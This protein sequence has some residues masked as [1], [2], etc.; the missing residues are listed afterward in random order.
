MNIMFDTEKLNE[1]MTCFYTLTKIR[2]VMFDDGFHP[3][4]S[5]PDNDCGFCG[6][7]KENPTLNERCSL[8]DKNARSV[9]RGTDNIYLYTCHAGLTEAI[10]PVKMNGMILG[11]VMLGQIIDKSDK[12]KKKEDILRY[13]ADYISRDLSEEY[14][15]LTTKNKKQI[16]AAANIMKACACYLWANRLVRVNEDCLSALISI[17]IGNNLIADLSVD[18]LCSHFHISRN[19]LYKISRDSYGMGIAA[20]VRKKRVQNAASLLKAGSTVADA[21]ISSGFEDYNYF[22]EIFKKE[23]GILPSKYHGKTM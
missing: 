12:Q 22:S 3:L 6:A 21:A 15:K 17:Y 11:Y 14:E 19:K 8:C 23:T 13:A 16:E 2:I 20:Y 10:A 5:V 9:C 4:I 7:L 1:I 18:A